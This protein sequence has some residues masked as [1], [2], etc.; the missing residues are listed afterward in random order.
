M[1]LNKYAQ[2]IRY[3]AEAPADGGGD[4]PAAAPAEAAPA[5]ADVKPS[6]VENTDG[7][8]P[9]D[10]VNP[11]SDKEPGGEGEGDDKG[12]VD[13]ADLE[14]PDGMVL[15]EKAVEAFGPLVNEMGLNK[16]QTQQL[17]T[18]FAGL[19]QAEAQGQ[20][21]AF[22]NQLEAWYDESKSDKEFGGDKFEESSKLAVQAVDKFGTPELKELMNETGFGNNPEFIRFMYRVGKAIQE[23]N[24]GNGGNGPTGSRDRVSVLYPS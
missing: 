13:F 17:A 1:N 3:L 10:G 21:E 22:S 18:A 20:G 14:L 15:D 4:A 2:F 6:D 7:S 23:D 11:D 16:E 8:D 5:T 24:P 12:S 19:K 9:T